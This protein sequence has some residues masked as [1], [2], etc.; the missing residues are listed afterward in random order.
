VEAAMRAF[1]GYVLER[2]PRSR[3]FLDD[4]RSAEDVTHAPA[5]RQPAGGPEEDR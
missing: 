2:E 5:A 3:R 1:L 4:V